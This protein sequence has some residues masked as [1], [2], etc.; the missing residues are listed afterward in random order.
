MERRAVSSKTPQVL[1][2]PPS[3]VWL[4]R[5]GGTF[6]HL[7]LSI[8]LL[9]VTPSLL[10]P[11]QKLALCLF[12]TALH[13]MPRSSPVPGGFIIIRWVIVGLSPL[14][15]LILYGLM[16]NKDTLWPCYFCSGVKDSSHWRV[17]DH[18]KF[19]DQRY[20]YIWKV[21]MLCKAPSVLT[22]DLLFSRKE[23]LSATL[24]LD[25]GLWLPL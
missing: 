1:S 13:G 10:V 7:C 14:L 12:V 9:Q 3:A 2:L 17:P 6:A 16:D 24:L 20:V 11:W 25:H 18:R 8:L 23:K 5:L 4:D 21:Y 19:H 15:I 22:A